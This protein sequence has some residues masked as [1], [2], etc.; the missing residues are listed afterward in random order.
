MKKI[1][2]ITGVLAALLLSSL[3][4]FAQSQSHE[5]LVKEI[6]AKLDELVALEK[7]LVQPAEEDRAKYADFLRTPG[8]GLIRLLPREIYDTRR[9]QVMR[10][11]AAPASFSR[12]QI[13]DLPQ[14]QSNTEDTSVRTKG[15]DD[16][17]WN[18]TANTRRLT[19][20]GGGAYYSFT[21]KTHE[22][23][24]GSDISLERGN[25][26]VGFAGVDYGLMAIVGDVPLETI[27]LELP[28]VNV[29]ASYK[30]PSKEPEVR[31]EQR[32]FSEGAEVDGF[33]VQ[34]RVPLQA[35]STY[36]LRSFNYGRADVLVAFRVVRVDTDG[37]AIILWKLLKK[38]SA[39]QLARN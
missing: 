13:S 4:T 7:R 31:L 27:G 1:Y 21:R 33:K 26:S 8:T 30:P 25:L 3:T 19:I 17:K 18:V 32:R 36:L 34:R 2:V 35:G 10:P 12:S 24:Q 5:D 14:G 22:Y 15:D 23:G 11:V 29:L 20:N 38:F 39:P 37:S 6:D 16:P 28:E 9:S